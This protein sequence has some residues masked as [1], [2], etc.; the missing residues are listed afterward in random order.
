MTAADRP[1]TRFDLSLGDCVAG[2]A[3]LPPAS[4]DLVVTSPPYNLGIQYGSYDDSKSTEDYLQWAGEW[5]RQIQ[6]VLKGS[7]SFFLNVGAAPSNPLLPHRLA[8][9][10][11]GLF[12]LQNTFHWI[13]SITIETAGGEEISAG[14]FKPINSERYV[15]DCHEYLFHFTRP[16]TSSCPASPSASPMPTS[17]ISPVGATPR[18]ATGAAAATPGLCPTKPFATVSIKGRI[19]RPSPWRSPKCA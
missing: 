8:L 9:Q 3:A 19:P 16:A 13:K 18:A 5:A 14:H 17:P 6:R 12:V 15:N 7:G 2:M 1:E 4:V 11:A 10:M